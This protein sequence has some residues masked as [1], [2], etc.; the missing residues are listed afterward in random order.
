VAA[1]DYSWLDLMRA[2]RAAGW[3]MNKGVINAFA[4]SAAEDSTRDLQAKYVNSQL[5]PSSPAY[6]SVDRGPWQL[7][8]YYHAEVSDAC[9]YDLTCS[10][11]Q[12]RRIYLANKSSFGAWSAWQNGRY[13]SYVDLGYAVYDLDNALQARDSLQAQ[14]NT[15]NADKAAL[16]AQ[17]TAANTQVSSLQ[18]QVSSLSA[19]L[20]S[21][22]QQV[23]A[24]Q[25]QVQQLTDRASQDEATIADLQTQLAAS[26]SREE[27]LRSTLASAAS[28][29]ATDSAVVALGI[30]K[31][32]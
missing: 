16:Q 5:D 18:A 2:C 30:L 7:N 22:N 10:T 31:G 32:E 20:T 14:L 13:K 9:A 21:A 28:T 1:N 17:L 24:L 11:Q 6:N 29:L 19:A 3:E 12:A 27:T 4:V 23:A 8:S 15:A 25:T 26:Q